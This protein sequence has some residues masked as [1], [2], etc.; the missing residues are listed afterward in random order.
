M[1]DPVNNALFKPG[2]TVELGGYL[3]LLLDALK[4]S[5]FD[6]ELF[7]SKQDLWFN[8]YNKTNRDK[9]YLSPRQTYDQGVYDYQDWYNKAGY[10]RY[11][12]AQN[13]GIIN[14]PGNSG[15]NAQS[16]WRPDGLFGANTYLRRVLNYT[17]QPDS[18]EKIL[19][20]FNKALK[21]TEYETYF[22]NNG[23]QKVRRKEN[24]P[25]TT[26]TMSVTS[27]TPYNSL[28][29]IDDIR[30]ANQTQF[31]YPKIP[32]EDVDIDEFSNIY[33]IST[34]NNKNVGYTGGDAL[35]PDNY[36]KLQKRNFDQSVGEI[37]K[38]L[39]IEP[40][41][42]GTWIKQ[43]SGTTG[44]VDDKFPPVKYNKVLDWLYENKQ[45]IQSIGRALYDNYV[46]SKNF[47]KLKNGLRP[48]LKIPEILYR[49]VFGNYA[50]QQQYNNMAAAA[51]NKAN[52]AFSSDTNLTMSGRLE[53]FDKA[54]K[55]RIQGNIIDNKAIASTS[56]EAWKVGA[57]NIENL[58]KAANE[59]NKAFVD[60]NN[61]LRR[62]QFTID[63]ENK[64]NI[65]KAWAEIQERQLIKDA[66]TKRLEDSVNN[67]ILGWDLP[68]YNIE[69]AKKQQ[70]LESLNS[71][72]PKYW[73][74]LQELQ[75]LRKKQ[76]YERDIPL[77]R[78][79]GIRLSQRSL[80][81]LKKVGYTPTPAPSRAY[82]KGG[83]IQIF[84]EGGIKGVE[85]TPVS[86]KPLV[87]ILEASAKSS[88]KGT[89]KKDS[90]SDISLKDIMSL[91]TNNAKGL[92][93][94]VQYLIQQAK[95]LFQT[96][97]YLDNPY[98][99]FGE[100]DI[101]IDNSSRLVSKYLD[102]IGK[103]NLVSRQAEQYKNAYT[104]ARNNKTLS[105]PAITSDGMLFVRTKQG[106][107][108]VTP[109]DYLA[110]QDT[111]LPITN[112]NLL[113]LREHD[114][115]FTFNTE[116]SSIVETGVSEDVVV[117]AVDKVVNSLGKDSTETGMLV[118][119]EGIAVLQ[120]LGTGQIAKVSDLTVTQQRQLNLALLA[121][122][123]GLGPNIKAW[124]KVK[125]GSDEGYRELLLAFA[126]RKASSTKKF[127]ISNIYDLDEDGKVKT[128][129]K[130]SGDGDE[131][132]DGKK[133]I[134]Q[135]MI[136]GRAG[137]SGAEIVV[138]PGSNGQ[139]RITE[140]VYY[141]YIP[142]QD[143]K[144]LGGNTLHTIMSEGFAGIKA[145][146]RVT[147][148][149]KLI[150]GS[151][152]HK[153]AYA[154]EGLYLAI[155]PKK[156]DGTVNLEVAE[157][158]QAI[159]QS[160]LD[161]F[162]NRPDDM[163]PEDRQAFDER[164]AQ[165]VQQ[166][167]ELAYLISADG[168]L[169]PRLFGKFFMFKAYGVFDSDATYTE[170]G[171]DSNGHPKKLSSN[172]W[173]QEVSD[174]SKIQDI[175]MVFSTDSKTPVDLDPNDGLVESALSA[176]GLNS[177]N[178]IYEGTVYIPVTDNLNQAGLANKKQNK[179][180]TQNEALAQFERKFWNMNNAT[181]LKDE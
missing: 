11:V 9:K 64:Q 104:I 162:T 181:E 6:P 164:V 95:G 129:S 19:D 126:T 61:I 110:H 168:T 67:S 150:T 12:V 96:S 122:E 68:N 56:E 53:A 29:T 46:N 167:P 141:P 30:R 156:A 76:A 45:N 34:N 63:T 74:A 177:F 15:D 173:I 33:G 31:E 149:N 179:E 165:E 102:I 2:A 8:L 180:S 97:T 4:D 27:T 22:D 32:E 50:E 118:P 18:Q 138:N 147:F 47:E 17:R 133:T 143:G 16:Q 87:S 135:E 43:Q 77:T 69:I 142:D 5:K 100:D 93:V 171:T 25:T 160:V 59:N 166:D 134:Y 84:A 111:M 114:P 3:E 37:G 151:D 86:N 41:K 24:V 44:R 178:K 54:N 121:L 7:N 85:Y 176:I 107:K 161:E 70:E 119:K 73:E 112:S 155:L 60:L 137:N 99:V 66:E 169:N 88:G 20:K 131:E 52:Q 80:D 108:T 78:R 140:A 92:K 128:S 79:R 89:K 21:D 139:F 36:D 10:N 55:Y 106:Y 144:V 51:E 174:S 116:I 26:D 153:V 130:K 14:R 13:Q 57:A 90:D 65:D 40:R 172:P 163:T 152:L 101:T 49:K 127:T 132:E 38:R 62:Y 159:V 94:D 82:K 39:G 98:D 71:T 113:W 115:T 145:S 83:R 154:G 120:L 103:I 58:T 42:V 48:A 124:L 136:S 28:G 123:R 146:N 117:N 158:Y 148:G 109:E 175:Q 91:L 35:Q 1:T 105:D 23:L 72:D 170:D 75:E 81:I 157:R 125:G